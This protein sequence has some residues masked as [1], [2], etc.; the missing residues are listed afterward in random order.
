MKYFIDHNESKNY[1]IIQFLNS[2][3]QTPSP[4]LLVDAAVNAALNIHL[5]ATGPEELGHIL[6]FLTGRG[7]C[8]SACSL[9]MRRL[10]ELKKER[11]VGDAI[12]MPLY[13]ALPSEDQ[14]LVFEPAP[15]VGYSFSLFILS[16]V[17]YNSN[18][19]FRAAVK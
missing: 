7:E 14:A 9:A 17:P 12:V 19:I 2:A 8:E 13:G 15:E 10:D 3:S 1:F 16:I 4:A 11:E 6:V 5:T 18:F